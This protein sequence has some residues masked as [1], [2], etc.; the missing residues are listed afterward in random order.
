M[1]EFLIGKFYGTFW[2]ADFYAHD[3]V[4]F[5]SLR[6]KIAL[7]CHFSLCARNQNEAVFGG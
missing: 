1:C 3:S 6:F 2:A 5:T 4:L 7:M